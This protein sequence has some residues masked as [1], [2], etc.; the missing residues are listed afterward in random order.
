MSGFEEPVNGKFSIQ[1]G[2]LRYKNRLVISKS[3]TLIPAILHTYHDSIFGGYS[4]FLRTYK[5]LARE[6]YWEGMKQGV[7]KYYE[8]CLIC[9]HNKSLALSPAGLLLPLE[10]PKQVWSDISMDFVGLPKASGF[11]IIFL[12]VDHLSKYGHF[13]AM[14]HPYT[15]KTVADLFI[16]EIVRLHGFPTCIDSDSD[17]VFLSHFLKE[18]FRLAGTKLNRSI[19]YHP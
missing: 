11:E 15:T 13:L 18:L 16:K 8:E 4:G 3:S 19:A 1:Q 6:L 5:R 9:Q 12:V 2:M 10:I 17:K 7:K 14:K